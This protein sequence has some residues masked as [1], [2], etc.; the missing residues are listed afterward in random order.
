M[1]QARNEITI[2]VPSEDVWKVI[3]D[4]TL[5]HKTNPGVVKAEGRMD[6]L[7]ATRTCE[8]DNKGRK[9]SITERLIEMV[10]GKSTVWTVESDTMGMS[11]M[12]RD[13]RFC[14]FLEPLNAHTTKLVAESHYKPAH[15]MARIMNALMMKKMMGKLQG[16]I[17][18]NI[19]TITEHK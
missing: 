10:P 8:V 16:Q 19:K 13:T 2:A 1:L 7:N 14:F 5:L 4:I 12:L 15:L 6:T 18:N 3:T 11:K 17:L 9:G